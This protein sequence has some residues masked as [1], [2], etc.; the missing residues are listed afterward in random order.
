MQA[1]RGAADGDTHARVGSGRAT[2]RAIRT[3]A[4]VEGFKGVV[5]LLVATGLLSLVHK[6]LNE[7]AMRWVEHSHLNPASKYPQIFVDAMSHLQ[8]PRLLW[9]AAGAAAYSTV[10]LIEAYGLF[11]ER[12][13][14]EWLAA[15]SGGLYIPVEIV[16]IVRK[17][18]GLT[19]TVLV[20]NVVVVAVMVWALVARQRK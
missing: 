3:I 4:F 14:A 6:D 1:D 11:R 18:T 7:V 16:E 12:A 15:L 19:F 5:V 20:V 10:R 9:L 13:W 8:E 2:R 17:P